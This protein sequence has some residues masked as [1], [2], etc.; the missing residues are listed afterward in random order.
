MIVSA[1]VSIRDMIL[2]VDGGHKTRRSSSA[3]EQGPAHLF[4]LCEGDT[5]ETFWKHLSEL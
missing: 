5:R 4:C 3:R 1:Q 2:Y